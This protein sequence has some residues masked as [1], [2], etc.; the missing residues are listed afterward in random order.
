MCCISLGTATTTPGRTGGFS[1]SSGATAGQIRSEADRLADLLDQAQPTPR[2]VVMNSCSSG[3]TG[4]N[5]VFSSTAAT[6]VRRGIS[7]V[8][9][10]Q[11]TISDTAAIAFARG[12]YTA[13]ACGRSV[14]EA[15]RSGRIS[16]LGAPHTLEWVTPVLYV[17][18]RTARLFNMTAP[19]A[20]DRENPLGQQTSPADQSPAT[21]Q[22][23]RDPDGLAAGAGATLNDG[24]R[25]VGLE[26]R[27]AQAR[28]NEDNGD[29]TGAARK[30]DEILEIDSA[31]RDA[32]ERRDLCRQH[33]VAVL[34]SKLEE[35][36]AAEDWAQVAAT[37]EELS[38]LDPSAAAKPSYTEL[39]ARARLE[40][41]TRS[42]EP[43]RIDFGWE[44][45]AVCWH[46]GGA[47]I[48]VAGCFGTARVYA[49]SS[50][51][52]QKQYA[53]KAGSWMASILDVTFSP[54]FS[55]LA[56]ASTSRAK[57]Q[58]WN[59][60][61]GRKATLT[62][63]TRTRSHPWHSARTAPTWPPPA[64]IRALGSGMRRLG[65][66]YLKFPTRTRSHPWHSARTAPA[67]HRQHG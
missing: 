24:Q 4:V 23:S 15:M 14:D 40:L 6:L 61:D 18:G 48:A 47:H 10:M 30:Y 38:G 50:E 27:Y 53:V 57:I 22:S 56:T 9:A 62:S 31:Y 20:A 25:A 36:A 32:A 17:R 65:R 41:G 67:G 11:F 60:A 12:F 39:A 21:L 43:L 35:Q 34:Q 64:R 26:H 29:W 45:Y 33:Q 28:A 58:V 37:N 42:P 8:A 13:I 54:D 51:Q 16:I 46:P 63:A 59:T 19:P 7:A 55:R 44:V 1:S 66:K 52:P 3:H 2:L 49:I 5:G